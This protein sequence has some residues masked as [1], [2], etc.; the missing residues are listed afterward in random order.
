[1][2]RDGID[3]VVMMSLRMG[4]NC[5]KLKLW[6]YVIVAITREHSIRDD[7]DVGGSHW[8]VVV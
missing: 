2:D 7:G 1:M 8:I 6:E 5:V 4:N 3:G